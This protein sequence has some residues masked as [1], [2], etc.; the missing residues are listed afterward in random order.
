[1]LLISGP[2]VAGDGTKPFNREA[3]RVLLPP[4]VTVTKK[5]GP[6]FHDFYFTSADHERDGTGKKRQ[7]FFAYVGFAPTFQR[8]AG[9]NAELEGR[10]RQ[11]GPRG[12]RQDGNAEQPDTCYA[13]PRAKAP[14]TAAATA[15]IGAAQH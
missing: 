14:F 5:P 1:M 12:R 11:A 8:Q 13:P 6:S 2:T 7:V 4:I 9:A 10:Q 15:K 3:P